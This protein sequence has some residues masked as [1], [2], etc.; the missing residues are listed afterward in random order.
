[1]QCYDPGPLNFHF[2]PAPIQTTATP[3]APVKPPSTPAPVRPSTPPR[4][5]TPPHETPYQRQLQDAW[6]E[7]YEAVMKS[8]SHHTRTSSPSRTTHMRSP[9]PTPTHVILP[10]PRRRIPPRSP[11]TPTPMIIEP[12]PP[13]PPSNTDPET[14]AEFLSD[15][16]NY[17][18]VS[19][20]QRKY[21]VTFD[22]RKDPRHPLYLYEQRHRT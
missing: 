2:P 11:P 13:M 19:S 10:L 12:T 15:W 18:D 7:G 22:D 14:D 21:N 8:P 5:P 20:K 6:E 9:T 16:K 17:Y 3:P 1:M 4:V